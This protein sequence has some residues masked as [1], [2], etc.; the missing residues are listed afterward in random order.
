MSA[1]AVRLDFAAPRVRVTVPGLLLL[2]VGCVAATVACLE[3]RAVVGRKAGLELRL[4]ASLRHSSRDPAS[5]ARALRL[6]ED[7]GKIA[8]ELGTPWT[9]VLS[10]LETASRDSAGAISVL[11]I[12]PDHDK[13]RVRISGESRDLAVALDYLQKLQASR[14]LRYPMLDSHEVVADNKDHPVRFALTAQW[15]ELP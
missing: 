8:N 11:S 4:A 14:S 9:A 3:Y 5:S 13:R 15:R 12:E 6:N 2:I 10:D 7:A 1:P